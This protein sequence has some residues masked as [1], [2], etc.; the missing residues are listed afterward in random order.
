MFPRASSQVEQLLPNLRH[1]IE[2]HNSCKHF[3]FHLQK[4]FNLQNSQLKNSPT[5]SLQRQI[6]L[7]QLSVLSISYLLINTSI[8]YADNTAGAAKAVAL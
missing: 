2:Q 1:L 7:Q 5:S 6:D 4:S 3:S 8:N